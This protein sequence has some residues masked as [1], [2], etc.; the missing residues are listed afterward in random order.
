MSSSPYRKPHA[1]NIPSPCRLH[2]PQTGIGIPDSRS[3]GTDLYTQ[4]EEL[5]W[6]IDDPQEVFFN[7]EILRDD[8]SIFYSVAKDT[9]DRHPSL[10]ERQQPRKAHEGGFGGWPPTPTCDIRGE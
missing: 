8:P 6:G 1:L 10:P 7:I 9:T 5:G 3:K 4:L 2:Q